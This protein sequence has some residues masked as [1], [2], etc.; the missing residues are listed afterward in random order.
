M[1]FHSDTIGE[2]ETEVSQVYVFND[3]S[4]KTLIYD[5]ENLHVKDR[6]KG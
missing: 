3:K 2:V 1:Q 5:N 6:F 4:I